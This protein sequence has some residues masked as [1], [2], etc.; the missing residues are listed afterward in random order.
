[1][2][3]PRVGRVLTRMA[4]P[5]SPRADV[6]SSVDHRRGP[7]LQYREARGRPARPKEIADDAGDDDEQ[8]TA[9]DHNEPFPLRRCRGTMIGR[10]IFDNHGEAARSDD[11]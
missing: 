1:M 7:W 4:G 2:A 11:R 3:G 5:A 8:A 10:G 6:W 9:A